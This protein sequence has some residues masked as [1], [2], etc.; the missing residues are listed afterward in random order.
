MTKY[1]ANLPMR[2]QTSSFCEQL[3]RQLNYLQSL[4]GENIVT[5]QCINSEVCQNDGSKFVQKSGM[6]YGCDSGVRSLGFDHNYALMVSA[7]DITLMDLAESGTVEEIETSEHVTG[8]QTDL[9]SNAD[10]INDDVQPEFCNDF[11]SDKFDNTGAS[12]LSSGVKE[13]SAV[14]DWQVLKT[15]KL[16]L[17]SKAKGRPKGTKQFRC[18]G[19][20]IKFLAKESIINCVTKQSISANFV[21]KL[22]LMTLNHSYRRMLC[23]SRGT[24]IKIFSHPL[25]SYS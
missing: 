23:R 4:F 12:T 20:S 17:P 10:L 24:A 6:P 5:P 1:I 11:S 8:I 9:D 18:S 3:N 22:M 2:T 19:A 14:D 7:A 16:P 13:T 21:L 15:A 25:P